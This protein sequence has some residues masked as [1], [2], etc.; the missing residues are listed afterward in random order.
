MKLLIADDNPVWRNLISAAVENWG[1]R[2]ELASDGNEAYELLQSDDPPRLA[3]LDWL[4]PGMEGVEICRRI[5]Q[6][7]ENPFTYII[8]L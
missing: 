3:L 2:I 5:K 7:P 1:Y 8:L 6:D 4:M